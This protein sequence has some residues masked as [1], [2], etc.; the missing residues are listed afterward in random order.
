MNARMGGIE[1]LLRFGELPVDGV[2][3]PIEL[4]FNAGGVGLVAEG[5]QHRFHRW[6]HVLR[7]YIHQFA[8]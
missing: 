4:C 6:P 3:E 5:V 2:Q 1:V 7:R 8:P